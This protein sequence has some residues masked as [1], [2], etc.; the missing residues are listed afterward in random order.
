MSKSEGK[1]VAKSGPTNNSSKIR[2]GD[3]YTLNV[4]NPSNNFK[5]FPGDKNG[6]PV[7]VTNVGKNNV[8][9]VGITKTKSSSKYRIRH[10]DVEGG[11]KPVDGGSYVNFK[12][13]IIVNKSRLRLYL[14]RF[15]KTIPVI[16]FIIYLIY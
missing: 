16:V 13:S 8:K 6:R 11:F 5:D 2:K 10:E 9:V 14:G 4:E 12:E 1:I 7:M 15:I 3:I